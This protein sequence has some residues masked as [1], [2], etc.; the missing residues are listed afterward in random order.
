VNHNDADFETI[1]GFNYLVTHLAAANQYGKLFSLE[2]SKFFRAKRS[3]FFDYHG[4]I[5][6]DVFIMQKVCTNGKDMRKVLGLLTEEL[7]AMARW[8]EEK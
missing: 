3:F 8:L 5:V 4:A 2:K 7:N 6:D 1:Y